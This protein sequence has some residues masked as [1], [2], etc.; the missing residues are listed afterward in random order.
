MPVVR[1]EGEFGEFA[2]QEPDGSIRPLRPAD[3]QTLPAEKQDAVLEYLKSA[4][5]YTATPRVVQEPGITGTERLLR[6]FMTDG[7]FNAMLRRR[8]YTI[9]DDAMGRLVVSKEGESG[10]FRPADPTGMTSGESVKVFGQPVWHD[11]F[12]DLVDEA[13][14]IIPAA[15][16]AQVARNLGMK[17]A[18]MVSG[19]GVARSALRGL[20]RTGTEAAVTGAGTAGIE[21]ARQGA[22][23]A[24]AGGP[25]DP[26]Q[27][28]AAGVLGGAAQA[29]PVAARAIQDVRGA[30]RVPVTKFLARS[31]RMGGIGDAIEEDEM[32]RFAMRQQKPSTRQPIQSM[33]D[34]SKT[35]VAGLADDAKLIPEAAQ[36]AEIAVKAKAPTDVWS[37]LNEFDEAFRRVRVPEATRR[38]ILDKRAET[39]KKALETKGITGMRAERL[40]ANRAALQAALKTVP[41][42][43]AQEVKFFLQQVAKY[44]KKGM[45][46]DDAE[47]LRTAG[48]KAAG[49]LRKNLEAAIAR[50][51]PARG[52]SFAALNAEATRKHGVISDVVD[53]MGRS[54]KTAVQLRRGRSYLRQQYPSGGGGEGER[55]ALAR[56]EREFPQFA[57][58]SNA[59]RES[60][61]AARM[62]NPQ[63]IPESGVQ[64]AVSGRPTGF[65]LMST[66]TGMLGGGAGGAAVGGPAGALAGGL[67]GGALGIGLSSPSGIVRTARGVRATDDFFA[68][69]LAAL[70]DDPRAAGAL[71]GST[72][73]S[74]ELIQALL[75]AVRQQQSPQPDFERFLQGP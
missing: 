34:L 2:F 23:A 71:A 62:G 5:A 59:L 10:T 15:K 37:V 42:G 9:K 44:D 57:G 33:Q 54:G 60:T 1:G 26:A 48:S 75:D 20:L 43:G 12:T 4:A 31:A 64:M 39:V 50:A 49:V 36:A 30:A 47:A 52:A 27:I 3:V 46:P 65:G 7:G 6:Q 58:I 51:D 70:A 28:A 72:S 8:G 29:V 22:G 63:G 61:I 25:I 73:Q 40:M 45:L 68:P 11:D 74:D 19:S 66:L 56:L 41:S 32:L 14:A 24:V 16:V 21:A 53:V 35:L 69:L 67:A 18:G 55:E 17:A 13:I 38:A